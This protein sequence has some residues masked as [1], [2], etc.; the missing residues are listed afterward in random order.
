MAVPNA[1]GNI[2]LPKFQRAEN[3]FFPIGEY[4]LSGGVSGRR[5]EDDTTLERYQS[6]WISV[7][8]WSRGTEDIDL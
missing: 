7:S 4:Y 6:A 5:G 2:R 1:R 3:L 8:V